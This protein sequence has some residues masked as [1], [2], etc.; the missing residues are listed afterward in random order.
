MLRVLNFENV[1]SAKSYKPRMSGNTFNL[2]R[3]LEAQSGHKELSGTQ[4]QEA[5]VPRRMVNR[6]LQFK[7]L[8]GP[9]WDDFSHRRRCRKC[10]PCRQEGSAREV[11]FDTLRPERSKNHALEP[12]Q[13]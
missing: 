8:V 3:S 5:A 13:V 12:D 10:C 4:A 1:H 6:R 7:R 9:I 11:H 2:Q